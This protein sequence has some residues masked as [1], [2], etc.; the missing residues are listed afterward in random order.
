MRYILKRALAIIPSLFL[1]I[2]LIYVICSILPGDSSYI[3]LG[4]GA[5]IA[6][7]SGVRPQSGFAEYL[8]DMLT[9]DFGT[10]TFG[11]EQVGSLIRSH[12]WPTVALSLFSLLFTLLITLPLVYIPLL[13]GGRVSKGISSVL[14][15]ISLSLPSFV[16]GFALMLLLAVKLGLL[17]VAGYVQLLRSPSL[18]I[19]SLILPSLTLG[20]MHSGYLVRQLSSSLER[21]LS[22]PYISTAAAKGESRA[23]IILYE[24]TVNV[25]PELVTLLFQS[26]LVFLTSSAAVELIFSIPGLGYLTVQCIARRDVMTLSALVVIATFFSLVISFVSDVLYMVLDRRLADE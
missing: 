1:A 6:D 10:S 5:T 2:V 11:S 17:P 3:L 25:M 15:V 13:T 14:S 18:F 4:D 16:I 9:L 24:A 22:A 7:L 12:L 23:K 21:E 20:F 19:R 8:V 26:L